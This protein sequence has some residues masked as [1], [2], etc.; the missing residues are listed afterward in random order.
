MR[1]NKTITIGAAPINLATGTAVA[2]D[3]IPKRINRIL[4]QMLPASS[5]S[6]G[7]VMD[8]IGAQRVP[9]KA[10]AA[11]VTAVLAAATASSP[12][13]VYSDS[14]PD[15]AID[16]GKMWLDGDH[17]GDTVKVSYDLRV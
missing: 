16:L 8:G 7:Y 15:G 13:G 2:D 9:S 12:G 3:G 10:V 17:A 14:D 4:I 6:L 1:V 5:G 11:D